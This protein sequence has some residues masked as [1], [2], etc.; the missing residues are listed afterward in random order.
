MEMARR[1]TRC[2]VKAAGQDS[3]LRGSCLNF[4]GNAVECSTQRKGLVAMVM[5]LG[6]Q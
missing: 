4:Q 1:V 5:C 6:E 3:R 2:P